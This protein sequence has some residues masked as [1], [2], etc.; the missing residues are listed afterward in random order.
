MMETVYPGLACALQKLSFFECST[1]FTLDAVN[2]FVFLVTVSTKMPQVISIATSWTSQGV[3]LTAF[4]METFG[5]SILLLYNI[6]NGTQLGLYA[7]SFA[8]IAMNIVLL[9]LLFSISQKRV[10]FALYCTGVVAFNIAAYV[11]G[12]ENLITTLQA[13]A[14]LLF[15]AGSI[16]Q[17]REN[18]K[19]G[20]A[21][22]L[23]LSLFG[24]YAVMGTLREITFVFTDKPDMVLIIA[25]AIGTTLCFIVVGQIIAGKMVRKG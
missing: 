21:H 24:G 14:S 11:I 15:Y 17:I 12:N 5:I 8:S 19:E 13:G 6:Y 23:S 16:A 10:M 18:I 2:L 22:L 3:S 20:T 4:T 25:N 9:F 7:E 1:Q